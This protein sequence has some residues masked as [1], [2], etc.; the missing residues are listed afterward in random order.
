MRID[1]LGPVATAQQPIRRDGVTSAGGRFVLGGG[2]TAAAEAAGE[3]G[4]P[5]PLTSLDA[6]LALQADTD[7]R[8]QRRRA[9]RYGDDLLD[10]LGDLQHATLEERDPAA[11]LAALGR[12]LGA[13]GD[14]DDAHLAGILI[15]IEQRAAVEL[16]KRE[17][18]AGP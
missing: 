15:E 17:A 11:I 9:I 18:M 1:G 12:R 5:V 10:L 13:G 8:Q 6:I 16:A 4:L 14:S 2:G 3:A 7:R